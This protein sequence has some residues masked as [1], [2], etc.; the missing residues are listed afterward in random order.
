[1]QPSTGMM[2]INLFV[3]SSLMLWKVNLMCLRFAVVPAATCFEAHISPWP[4][5]LLDPVVEPQVQ[6]QSTGAG[7]GAACYLCSFVNFVEAVIDPRSFGVEP[8]VDMA[9]D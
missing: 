1:M 8:E 3:E 9:M 4:M 5:T 2:S 7:G 6:Q